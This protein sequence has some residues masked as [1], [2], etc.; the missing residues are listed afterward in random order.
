[1]NKTQMSD[2]SLIKHYVR[3]DESCFEVLVTRHKD[4]IFGYIMMLKRNRTIAQDIFQETF[5]RI[6][7][8]LKKG[9]YMEEGKFIAW[10]LKIAHNLAM[11]GY[12]EDVKMP[13]ISHVKER[14]TGEL[15]DIFSVLNIK[16]STHETV[17]VK[18]DQHK[19]LKRLI[20]LL[21]EEQK[22]S[23]YMRTYLG[24]SFKEIAETTNTNMNTALGRFRYGLLR[25]REMVKTSEVFKDRCTKAMDLESLA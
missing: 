2:E 15:I 19:E 6:I 23:M 12:R 18:K 21:P 7:R 10:A 4:R 24:M 14:K 22:E 25:L 13:S 11:D 9:E 1:M 16:Q 3:G 8:H 20:N 17:V 5:F